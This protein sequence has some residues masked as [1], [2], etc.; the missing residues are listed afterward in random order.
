M[1]RKAFLGG[2]VA[3]ALMAAAGVIALMS[4]GS[5]FQ[6]L[7]YKY[8]TSPKGLVFSTPRFAVVY[9][10]WQISAAG[11]GRFTFAGKHGTI[12][13]FWRGY[14]LTGGRMEPEVSLLTTYEP[15][16]GDATI[17]LH[18]QLM[19]IENN[20]EY[21]RVQN[22]LI[23]LRGSNPVV[24]VDQQGIARLPSAAEQQAIRKS[25]IPWFQDFDEISAFPGGEVQLSRAENRDGPGERL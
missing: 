3:G 8:G 12:P 4:T 2:C 17:W 21:L 24:V 7:M 14:G 15:G 19:R 5:P 20:G 6:S 9:E 13:A 16:F 25:L 1:R 10:D 11:S 23:P 18:G 22:Q